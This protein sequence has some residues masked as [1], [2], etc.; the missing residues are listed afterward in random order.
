MKKRFFRQLPTHSASA[1]VS[2]VIKDSQ[3]WPSQC[4]LDLT[5]Q[6]S[7]EDIIW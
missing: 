5:P 2:D 4:Q 6:R 7:I 3:L 1:F